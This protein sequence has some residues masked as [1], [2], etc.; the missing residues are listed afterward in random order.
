M[1]TY[2]K[3]FTILLIVARIAY[4]HA[5]EKDV[6]HVLALCDLLKA[7]GSQYLLTSL[8]YTSQYFVLKAVVFLSLLHS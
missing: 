1:D 4:P 2:V 6:Q 8:C 5:S 7:S 3:T